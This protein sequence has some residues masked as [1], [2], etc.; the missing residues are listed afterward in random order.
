MMRLKQH[1]KQALINHCLKY[2]PWKGG[3]E[4]PS[5]KQ[6]LNPHINNKWMATSMFLGEGIIN[7]PIFCN[8]CGGPN[9]FCKDP[10]K[11]E[12][13]EGSLAVS[14]SRTS[15][16][17]PTGNVEARSPSSRTQYLKDHRSPQMSFCFFSTY[18]WQRQIGPQ[19][20]EF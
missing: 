11:L 2:N 13:I 9:S 17:V 1:Q 16:A 19:L 8:M 14:K 6:L 4:R 3:Q 18:G 20:A 15:F 7:P 5:V 12:T 10:F